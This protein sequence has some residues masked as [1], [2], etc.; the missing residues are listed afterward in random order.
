MPVRQRVLDRARDRA[1][2]VRIE[3]GGEIRQARL[4]AGLR[5]VDVATAIGRSKSWVSRVERGRVVRV[6]LS[7]LVLL[8]AAVGLKLWTATYPSERALR[9]APQI[10]LL[11]RFRDRVGEGWSWSYE[12]IGPTRG[13]L[14]AAD[15]VMRRAATR[16]M[17]E[18][19]TRFADTQAQTRAVRVKARDLGID[20][21][22]IVVAESNANRRALASASD[23]LAA[24]FP[25]RTRS[26]LAALSAG[27][28]PGAN[29]IVVV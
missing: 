7:D 24:D 2:L 11:R 1:R 18:A 20:R 13:D 26:V 8:A 23:I 12:V 17:V 15:A 6:S 22:I 21:V 4:A 28:D 25:L 16:I 27:R 5:L 9:D 29:G 14:R 10:A 3:V 19:F